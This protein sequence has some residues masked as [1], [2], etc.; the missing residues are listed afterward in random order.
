MWFS[1]A[2]LACRPACLPA[3]RT[4]VWYA[5][6]LTGPPTSAPAS[7]CEAA[8]AMHVQQ[9]NH[10]PPSHTLNI[11]PFLCTSFPACLR[12]CLTLAC[13]SACPPARRFAGLITQECSHCCHTPLPHP[14]IYPI[15][16]HT[17]NPSPKIIHG[18][19]PP[20]LHILPM[21]PLPSIGGGLLLPLPGPCQTVCIPFLFHSQCAGTSCMMMAHSSPRPCK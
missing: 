19:P 5:R 2:V 21:P 16:I 9:S 7:R 14:L 18:Q 3:C 15:P 1:G 17:P 4:A 8:A 13:L 6:G 10:A 20:L 11:S 12:A